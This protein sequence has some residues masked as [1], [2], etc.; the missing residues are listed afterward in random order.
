M[1]LNPQRTVKGGRIGEGG[2]E[3]V[4]E[5]ARGGE[6]GILLFN[7]LRGGLHSSIAQE[8]L[9]GIVSYSALQNTV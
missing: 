6:G 4:G 5:L 8:A 7:C 1:R 3:W 2:E 9:A